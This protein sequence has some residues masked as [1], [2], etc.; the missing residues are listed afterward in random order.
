MAATLL[1]AILGSACAG[2]G[3]D[4]GVDL[5][6]VEDSADSEDTTTTEPEEEA[7]EPTKEEVAAA[8][9]GDST[10]GVSDD[11][12][13]CV[14]LAMVDAVGLDVLLDTGAFEQ[15]DEGS[16][17]SL[18][19]LGITLDES[20][21][22]ALIDGLHGCG[23]LRTM[24]QEEMSS[25]GSIPPEGAACMTDG[26]DDATIDRLFVTTITG[27]EAALNADTEL[28]DAITQATLDCIAAGVDVG[29]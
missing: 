13:M 14:G 1:V 10:G 12:A 29:E 11:D 23:D 28:L 3:S 26:L 7:G 24:L 4:E 20:Q 5:E 9:G 16:A 21:K 27:G 25:D 8:L 18:A 2:E 22:A 15:M 6:N 19:D 17:N